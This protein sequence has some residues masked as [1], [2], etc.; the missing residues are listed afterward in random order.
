MNS[1]ARCRCRGSVYVLVLMTSVFVAVVG[2]SA[3]TV[4]RIQTRISNADLDAAKAGYY[5]QS[6][7]DLG[8]YKAMTA[9]GWRATHTNDTWTADYTWGE[10]VV[11]YK[12]VDEIDGNL[13]NDPT[14]PVRLYG[15]ATVN[16][17][18]RIY[19]VEMAQPSGGGSTESAEVLFSSDISGGGGQAFIESAEWAGQYFKPTLPAGATSWSVTRVQVHAVKHGNGSDGVTKVQLRKADGS[20]VPTTTV[21]EEMLMYETSLA[22][23]T[24]LEF[25]YSTVT[26][27]S[28]SEGLC[29]VLE[30]DQGGTACKAQKGSS[31]SGL[32]VTYNAGSTWT[33]SAST[34]LN[35]YI[36][37]KYITSPPMT[38]V[39]GTWRQE[40]Q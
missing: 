30:W 40:V 24:W 11:T 36:Y 18:V 31:G 27:L 21:L 7:V 3:M 26:G 35:H 6:M 20:N 9:P 10:A 8:L 32:L 29:L 22:S 37:G 13:A 16:N 4:G 17:A 12:F 19:S 23:A 2:L 38:P 34:S 28:P 14:Q 25:T 39:A 5:A 1:K 15:K 33:F